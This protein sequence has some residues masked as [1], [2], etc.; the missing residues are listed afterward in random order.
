MESKDSIQFEL[1][2]TR[3]TTILVV[4]DDADTRDLLRTFFSVRRLEAA[5]QV[6]LDHREYLN[7]VG[8]NVWRHERTKA[9]IDAKLTS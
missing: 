5:V 9:P 6:C 4:E 3:K 7:K 2:L 1:P 8:G